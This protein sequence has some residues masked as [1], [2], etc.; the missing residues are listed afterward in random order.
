MHKKKI[1]A[2]ACVLLA[3][4]LTVTAAGCKA[5]TSEYDAL[6]S[7]IADLEA[8]N[9]ALRA[10]IDTLTAQLGDAGGLYLS[11]WDLSASIWE[12]SAGADVFLTATPAAFRDGM[13]AEFLVYL[14]SQIAS[15]SSCSW[16]CTSFTARA[17]LPVADG[18]SY[19]CILTDNAGET[20]QILLSS[21]ESPVEDSLVYL[22]T[23][24]TA[25]CNLFLGDWSAQDGKLTIGY[26]FAQAQLPRLAE[27]GSNVGFRGARLVLRLNGM[28]I[29][30][31][32]LTL[33]EGEGEGSYEEAV[34]DLSFSIPQLGDDD[35][36][37]LV[38]EVTL[39][40]DGVISTIGGSWFLSDGN[41]NLV[42]G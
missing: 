24:L 17:A 8:E 20:S 14:D 7:K 29:D 13:T 38:L 34:Y 11:D 35:Q 31:Q 30:S 27:A 15:S 2:F 39:T 12:G 28:E 26:S 4:L 41:L 16:D 10:Q 25:Y 33:P 5:E 36:L 1:Q 37:D 42:V 18:Y 40:T 32:N 6:Q 21:P 9:A 3:A 22:Q 23:S 19:F